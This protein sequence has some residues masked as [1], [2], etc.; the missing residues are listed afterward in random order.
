MYLLSCFGN[1][2]ASSCA[3]PFVGGVQA[4]RVW[5]MNEPQE[6][7]SLG[8]CIGSIRKPSP[9]CYKSEKYFY[10]VSAIIYWEVYLLPT[11]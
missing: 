4:A 7:R 8:P 10:C 9:D 1:M 2:P 5:D 3:L 6:R 11:L